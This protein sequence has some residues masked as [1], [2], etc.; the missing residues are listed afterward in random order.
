MLRRIGIL[1]SLW[2][3]IGF[4][5]AAEP[6]RPEI[7]VVYWS[8]ADCRWCVWWE[9][10]MSG[11]EAR[12]RASPEFSKISFYTVKNERLQDPYELRHFP[13]GAGWLWDDHRGGDR[14]RIWRPSWQV[15]VDRK[16]IATFRGTAAWESHHWPRIRQLI[17]DHAKAPPSPGPSSLPP[18][19]STKPAS[20]PSAPATASAA[21]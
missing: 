11:M 10:S 12:F 19:H 2:L 9:S 15:Y 5:S 21:D 8:S 14:K 4:A 13:S 17:A 6:H 3:G 1:F 16:P 18:E 20:A 7:A